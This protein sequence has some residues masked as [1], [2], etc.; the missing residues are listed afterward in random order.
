MSDPRRYSISI[1][2]NFSDKP[3]Y[4][5]A[6][7]VAELVVY[8]Q[9]DFALQNTHQLSI[10]ID[11][12]HTPEDPFTWGEATYDLQPV[13]DRFPDTCFC[14]SVSDGEESDSSYRV[15]FFNYKN[16]TQYPEI[17]YP[18]FRINDFEYEA[19]EKGSVIRLATASRKTNSISLN[20]ENSA[21]K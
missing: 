16:V 10:G 5:I 14:L 11:F 8:K 4:E 20:E 9:E 18:D 19:S 2:E 15:L 13:F 21:K 1:L 6:L 7:Q 3:I 12:L 17:R